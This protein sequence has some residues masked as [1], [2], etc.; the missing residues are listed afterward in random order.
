MPIDLTYFLKAQFQNTKTPN[1]VNSTP[2]L[3]YRK[4]KPKRMIGR[5]L[6]GRV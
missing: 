3:A 4:T 1:P 2:H 5:Y 6:L